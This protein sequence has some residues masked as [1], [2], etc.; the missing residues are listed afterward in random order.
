MGN[1]DME[2]NKTGNKKFTAIRKVTDN[3]FFNL[4]AMD[5]LTNSGKPFGYYFGS[6]NDEEHIKLKTKAMNAEGIVI[7]PIVKDSRIKS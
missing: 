7:Y 5:A 4:Y 3:P 1:N 2:N 6:R